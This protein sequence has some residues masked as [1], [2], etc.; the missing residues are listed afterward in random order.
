MTISRPKRPTWSLATEHL[1]ASMKHGL[2]AP[3][4]QSGLR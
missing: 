4:V 3:A 2:L 1:A